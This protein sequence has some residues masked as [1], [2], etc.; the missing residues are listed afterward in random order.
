MR[1]SVNWLRRY[2]QFKL[3][4]DQLAQQLTS[5]GL[6][7]ESMEY[8][9]KVFSG[10]VVGEVVAVQKHPHADRLTICEVRIARGHR[11]VSCA[12]LQIVCGAPNVAVG[13]KVA[14]ASVGAVIPH[15]Q[16]DP[17]GISFTLSKLDVRG[18]ESN[19]M[20]CSEY[21][22]GLGD[23]AE[24]ILI[25]ESN[26][27]VGTPLANHLGL[28][29]SV[30]EVAVTPNRP[31]CLSHIGVAREVAAI[32]GG[33][34]KTPRVNLREEKSS[35]IHKDISVEIRNRSECPR[36]TARLVKDVNVKASPKWLQ[37]ILTAVDLRPVNNIVDITNFV[38]M[39]AGQPLHAF[40]YDKISGRKILVRNAEEGEPFTALDG[41]N[42]LLTASTLLICD[43]E[44]PVAIAG[45]MG[46]MNS[47][48][49]G[50]TKNVL[51]ESAYFEP[52]G[53]RNSVKKLGLSSDAAYRF[54]RGTDPEGTQYAADRASQ[55]MAELA[56]GKIQKGIVDVYPR[57]IRRRAITVRCERINLVLGTNLSDGVVKKVLMPLGIRAVARRR[58]NLRCHV[59]TFRPDLEQ[60]IDIIEEVARRIGFSSI[61]DKMATAVDFSVKAKAQSRLAE[62][63]QFLEGAGFNEVVTNSLVDADVARSFSSSIIQLRNPVSVELSAMRPSSVY[64]M[65]QTVSSNSNYGT[66]DLRLYEIG[67]TYRKVDRAEPNVIAGV[68]EKSVLSLCMTGRRSEITWASTD[69]PV[70]IYDLKGVVESL[71]NKIL[72][73][74]FQFIY[75][76][77]RSSLTDQTIAVEKN[78]TYVGFLGKVKAELLGK[79]S[80]ENDVYVSELSIRD[81]IP[82][83]RAIRSYSPAS[84]YPVVSRDLAFILDQRTLAEDVRQCMLE[85]GGKLL[86][87]ATVFD[88]FE[89]TP[90]PENKKSLAFSLQLNSAER[91][92]T[93]EE[94]EQVV[95][96]V[97][98]GVTKNFGAELRGA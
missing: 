23:N 57:K 49:S 48:I 61:G 82:Q 62:I 3:S 32:V 80:L 35:S 74:K 31:D 44:R 65:L 6:E 73:D 21:E 59:P 5:V 66:R 87:K 37:T 22:L 83:E 34:V 38:M 86:T 64:S 4:T 9:G 69:E 90:L 95:A 7:V 97:V 89:G 52:S 72:L 56:G 12:T 19:G 77:S 50:T 55:L 91:T 93:E 13:Q 51:I 10:F 8:L 68:E 17:G 58:G 88:V 29:D 94:I 2:I 39:E 46:G 18:V 26:A 25:L 41:K 84:R 45:V 40:D 98:A 27:K 70:D 78:G 96:R 33:K 1:I 75:Y 43:A 42:H 81:L 15:N 63:R 67:R 14:V 47:E 28:D 53:I 30:L 54:E 85:A 11:D 71:L 16:H 36:Y 79:F 24:G 60:E 76:D 20:I 92:L